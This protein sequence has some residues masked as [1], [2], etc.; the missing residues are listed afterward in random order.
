MPQPR[1]YIGPGRWRQGN[2]IIAV[3]RIGA[4]NGKQKRARERFALGTDPATI[5]AW[6]HS[7]ASALILSRPAA[8]LRGTLAADIAA[9]LETLPDDAYRKESTMLLGHWSRAALGQIPTDAVTRTDIV[10]QLSRW[11][12][13]QIG[14]ETRNKR[15]YRLR[16]FFL[17]HAGI[18][19]PNP[20]DKI[21]GKKPPEAE[22]RDFPVHIV[23]LI[24]DSLSDL[25]RAD[26]GNTRPTVSHS[27]LRLSVMAW[28]G[29][30]PATIQR[31]RKNHLHLESGR[32]YLTMRRKGQWVLG[33]S[34]SLLPP[35]VDAWRAFVAAGLLG[36]T[37][38]RSS[39]WKTFQTGI[40]RAERAAAAHAAE[41]GDRSW[42]EDLKKLPPN[43]H[44][45]DLRHCFG[46][47][48]YH[49]TGDLGA[50]AE[51][52]QHAD[53]EQ[54]RRYAK[55]AVSARVQAAIVSASGTYTT[56]PTLPPAASA[57]ERARAALRLVRAGGPAHP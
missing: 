41:T 24:L 38:S 43:V 30:A 21:K 55:G 14:L 44:P 31:V 4:A 50:V 36:K 34:L 56:I 23:K 37:W 46:A 32:I 15:L 9:Y 53:I 6:Q 47:Q 39:L 3:K 2:W 57:A 29:A 40:A 27:K 35:A 20:T 51:L 18:D 48:I 11:T 12:D 45:Y 49:E 10:T 26:K 7:A 25:G 52:M 28:T 54:T 33:R 42:I 1:I 5:D 19:A 22:P 16:V 13:D 17:A 8:E